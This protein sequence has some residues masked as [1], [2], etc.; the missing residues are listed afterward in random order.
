MLDAWYERLDADELTA[1]FGT[2]LDADGQ[3]LFTRTFQK[4]RRKTSAR[5]VQKLTELVDG[6]LRFASAPP[7]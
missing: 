1:R 7:L 2:K 4:G 6:R 3:E 5:A